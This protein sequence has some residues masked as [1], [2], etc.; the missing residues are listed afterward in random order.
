MANTDASTRSASQ[1][2]SDASVH[3]TGECM[4]IGCVSASGMRTVDVNA[5][6]RVSDCVSAS[7][8]INSHIVVECECWYL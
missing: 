5:L 8:R 2:M 4:N 1:P 3:C 7:M 6:Y